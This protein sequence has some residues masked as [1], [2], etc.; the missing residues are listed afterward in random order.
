M[1]Y[2][3]DIMGPLLEGTAV[4]IQVFLMTLVIAVPLG[5]CLALMRISRFKVLSGLVNGYI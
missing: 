4:T 2:V 1:N 5:L 3:F